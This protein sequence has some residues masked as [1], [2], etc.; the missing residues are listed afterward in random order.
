VGGE[1][2][3]A[4]LLKEDWEFNVLDVYN[5]NRSGHLEGYFTFVRENLYLSG[6]VL[7]AGVFKGK[8]LLGM[9]LMLKELGSSKKIYGYDTWA[10]FPPIHSAEDSFESWERLFRSGRITA[11]HLENAKLQVSHRALGSQVTKKIDSSNISLSGDFSG[12]VKADL[13]NKIAYLGLD[14]VVLVQGDFARTMTASASGPSELMAAIIDADL[15][16]SYKTAL[17]YIWPR[18]TRGG[19]L[20]LDEYYSL[21]FPGARIASD[22]FFADIADKPRKHASEF[23]HFERWYVRKTFDGVDDKR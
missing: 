9:A 5:Y 8:S 16:A 20:Y 1:L 10:G 4:R 22:E 23:G 11:R 19:Y 6:D 7:E 3:V 18:I 15:Y 12:A 17:P 14:N 21:K 2:T 13:E